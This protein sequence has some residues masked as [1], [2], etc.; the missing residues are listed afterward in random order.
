METTTSHVLLDA[1]RGAGL[2]NDTQLAAAQEAL[3]RGDDAQGLA[4]QLS[5][6]GVLTKWQYGKIRTGRFEE[7]VFG[8]YLIQDKIGEGGM[9]KVFKAVESGKKRVVALKTI[10]PQLMTN[11]LVLKRY[12]REANATKALNHPNVV[13]LF[14][15][16][17][18]NGRFYLSMEFVEGIDLS[19]IVKEFGHPPQRGLDD[20]HEACEYV[21]Q[22]ALGLQ[23]AHD[24]GFVHRD[25]K[26]SNMLVSGERPL[27]GTSGKATVK[28]LDM[29]LV[30]RI[31]ENEEST[32]TELTR[33]GT[34]V[35]TPDYMA[36]E[37]AKNSSTVDHRADLYSL[38]CTLY[39]MLRG[40]APFPEGTSID[41]LIRHQ[42]DAP[43][44]LRPLRPDVP[45]GVHQIIEKL[46]KKKPDERYSRSSEV[47]A[48]LA[49]FTPG[50]GGAAAAKGVASPSFFAPFSL[51]PDPPSAATPVPL[52]KPE[53]PPTPLSTGPAVAALLDSVQPKSGTLARTVSA[54]G[55]IVPPAARNAPAT[56]ASGIDVT[57]PRVTPVSS[58]RPGGRGVRVV[59]AAAAGPAPVVDAEVVGALSAT[60]VTPAGRQSTPV[61]IPKPRLNKKPQKLAKAK[62]DGP[63]TQQLVIGGGVAF[64]LIVGLIFGVRAL[65]GGGPEQAETAP[66]TAQTP[67][68]KPAA[69]SVYVGMPP[70]GQMLPPGAVAAMVA[71]PKPVWAAAAE[72]DL[73]KGA[74]PLIDSLIRRTRFDMRKFDR[75]TASFT[76][77]PGQYVVGGEAPFLT[78]KWVAETDSILVKGATIEPLPGSPGKKLKFGKDDAS[79]FFGAMVPNRVYAFSNAADA[80]AKLVQNIA[81]PGSG[82]PDLVG[83]FAGLDSG[84]PPLVAFA[85]TGPWALP[86]GQ[87]TLM[88]N[89]VRKA[90]AVV[91]F[92]DQQFEVALTLTGKDADSLKEF[93]NVVLAGKLTR[94]YPSLKGL[95]GKI[96]GVRPAMAADGSD[97]ELKVAATF[98]WAEVADAIAPLLPA[99]PQ[100]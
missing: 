24:L 38:G 32:R 71:Y 20:Y 64:A 57:N 77:K 36:P 74:S 12:E 6:L 31:L 83:A 46:L 68:A 93:V 96:A 94:Q 35:G 86:G 81:S 55:R 2:L 92:A 44:D 26:P 51:E 47:A 21:R 3:T 43:P 56:P 33:D 52:P 90:V 62:S 69:P 10:R 63:T 27:A 84:E 17:D 13:G 61:A 85:A 50:G 97:V 25:I 40:Q 58:P 41:K 30:R 16:G 23:A 1:L 98:T 70:A 18:V 7:V 53:A 99:P 59:P 5:A 48:A 100:G 39:Y 49:P 75:I 95:I 34:V 28:L 11:K 82:N 79:A 78:D 76:A 66:P 67:A 22:A 45:E 60:P 65:S 72:L 29:G 54:S 91:R 4:D 80:L 8:P 73:P 19:R 88:Q 14:D 37:Q 9:G 89:G 42:L 15:V 87:E